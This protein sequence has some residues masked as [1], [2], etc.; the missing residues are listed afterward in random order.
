VTPADHLRAARA[1]REKV[2][3]LLRNAV[4]AGAEAQKALDAIMDTGE[5][6]GLI[7]ATRESLLRQ[8]TVAKA[9]AQIATGI[10]QDWPEIPE[11]KG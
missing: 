1:A 9:I 11:G 2:T 10:L 3:N 7:V 5:S 4:E 8:R 6:I